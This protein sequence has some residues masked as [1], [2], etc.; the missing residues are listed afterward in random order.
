MVSCLEDKLQLIL[1]TQLVGLKIKNLEKFDP[2]D[3]NNHAKKFSSKN[4][5]TKFE[6]SIGKAFE[7]FKKKLND[8]FIFKI[9][10]FKNNEI[11]KR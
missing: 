7:K 4:F 10:N 9:L 6:I 5:K 11:S 3:L 8:I 2:Q 1:L